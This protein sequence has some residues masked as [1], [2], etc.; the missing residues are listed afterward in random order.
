MANTRG[1]RVIAIDSLADLGIP[2]TIT[3]DFPPIPDDVLGL[4]V[5]GSRAR[6]DAVDDSDLDILAL[7]TD[8]SPST[9]SGLVNVSFYTDTQLKTGIS[10]L[11][12][13]HLRRDARI[14]WDPN[15]KLAAILAELGDVDTQRLFARVKVMSE[16]FGSPQAD[17]PKYL[18]GLLREARY[19][20]RSSLYA[21]A[22]A[23]GD[24]CFSIRELADRH[25]DPQ[26][27]SLLASRQTS[28]PCGRDYENCLVRLA[29]LH[30]PLPK[31]RHGSLEALIVNEWENNGD[32][33]SVAFMALGVVGSGGDYAEVEKILL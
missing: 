3:R 25:S 20:L 33:L 12:G 31:N 23:D 19:L 30:G 11:F 29:A 5:Y 32:L 21:R 4:L 6:G 1:P 28:E 10:T 24:P 7:V 16:V 22:I 13:A 18:P 26:L 2:N 9:Q 17:L 27:V 8:S 15:G 14:L